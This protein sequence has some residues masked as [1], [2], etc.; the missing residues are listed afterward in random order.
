MQLF[1]WSH[2]AHHYIPVPFGACRRSGKWER[3][4]FSCH[5]PQ[6]KS[7]CIS[8]RNASDQENNANVMASGTE[9]W[10]LQLS[11]PGT[12]SLSG[13]HLPGKWWLWAPLTELRPGLDMPVRAIHNSRVSS[14]SLAIL[15]QRSHYPSRIS[16]TIDSFSIHPPPTLKI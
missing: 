10:V 11:A 6:L 12:Q 15:R 4:T 7:S 5:Y 8:C 16:Y 2:E 14:R 13:S 1:R 3:R 9:A